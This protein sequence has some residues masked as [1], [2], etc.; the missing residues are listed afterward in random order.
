MP[1]DIIVLHE[2]ALPQELH[3]SDD[4][5]HDD[6]LPHGCQIVTTFHDQR[7]KAMVASFQT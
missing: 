7:L 2:P 6:P 1:P 3:D 5:L 4:C